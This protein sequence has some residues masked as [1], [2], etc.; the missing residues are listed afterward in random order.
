FLW[1]NGVGGTPNPEL[2]HW[3]IQRRSGERG[4]QQIQAIFALNPPETGGRP[5][6]TSA[7]KKT[8]KNATAAKPRR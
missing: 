5:P 8:K 4:I 6:K 2:K 1:R 3:A 7:R